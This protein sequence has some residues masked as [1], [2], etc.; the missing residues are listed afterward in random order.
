MPD[1]IKIEPN[2]AQAL[3]DVTQADVHA[4]G[5]AASDADVQQSHAAAKLGTPTQGEFDAVMRRLET[6]EK[7]LGTYAP[8]LIGAADA[9]APE[10]KPLL[11]RLPELESKVASIIDHLRGQDAEP[12]GDVSHVAGVVEGILHAMHTV[13]GT[14]APPT[15]PPIGSTTRPAE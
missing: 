11:D 6:V 2:A 15:L 10:V 13:W 8:E 1:P 9:L 5:N 14:K 7:L 4:A 12:A 3:A